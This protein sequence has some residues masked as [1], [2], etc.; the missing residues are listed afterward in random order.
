MAYAP[1]CNTD[2]AR[3]VRAGLEPT[4]PLI[5]GLFFEK[6]YGKLFEYGERLEGD[7]WLRRDYP[8]IVYVGGGESRIAKVMKTVAYVV[9]DEDEYGL[10]VVEKWQLKRHEKFAVEWARREQEKTA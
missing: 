1:H 10:P 5:L 2:F 8:H 6:E 3:E 4:V 9:M 7:K